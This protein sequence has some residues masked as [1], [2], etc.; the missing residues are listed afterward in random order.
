[1]NMSGNNENMSRDEI[2]AKKEYLNDE[3][4]AIDE[5]IDELHSDINDIECEIN[6]KRL[7]IQSQQTEVIEIKAKIKAAEYHRKLLQDELKKS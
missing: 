5:H 2:K 3:I 7:A 1:M 4:E 6:I